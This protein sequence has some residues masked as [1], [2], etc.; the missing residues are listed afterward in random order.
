MGKEPG[1]QGAAAR[2]F[3]ILFALAG[4]GL[5]MWL[6]GR[7]RGGATRTRAPRT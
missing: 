2:I 5:G 6:F 7:G 3:W 4:L 1:K